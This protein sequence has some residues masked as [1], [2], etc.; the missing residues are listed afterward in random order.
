M[1]LKKMEARWKEE[2]PTESNGCVRKRRRPKK[3]KMM[4]DNYNKKK[5]EETI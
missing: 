4:L 2:L 1:N 5:L 3:W